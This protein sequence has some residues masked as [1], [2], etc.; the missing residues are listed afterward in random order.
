[1][2]LTHELQRIARGRLGAEHHQVGDVGDLGFALADADS[3]DQHNVE[4]GAEE[5]CGGGGQIRQAG[6]RRIT[7]KSANQRRSLD[8][9]EEHDIVFGIGPAGTGKTYL[10]M[11]LAVRADSPIKSVQDLVGRIKTDPQSVA[12]S[13]GSARGATP[14]C[15]YALV[16]KA[17]GVDP[18]RLKVITFGGA[19]ESV[20]NLLGGHIDLLCDQTST[21]SG[22]IKTGGIKTY[23]V[24]S[25]GRVATLPF[26]PTLSEQGLSGFEATSWFGLWAPKGLPKPVLDKLAAALQAADIGP[27]PHLV[28]IETRAGHGTGKPTDK[29][30]EETSDLWAFAAKWTGLD[31]KPV[32]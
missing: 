3:F 1:M 28:R 19:A 27:K 2:A 20:T 29:V 8:A 6:K 30:I 5:D 26:V 15:T 9:I 32:K 22:Q 24:T 23:G 7:A 16:A 12:V 18:R 10:A 11:A 14:H 25:K 31:V 17:A 13:V 21:T 4:Q